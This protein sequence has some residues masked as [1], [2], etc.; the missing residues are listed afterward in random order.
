[1]HRQYISLLKRILFNRTELNSAIHFTTSTKYRESQVA[2]IML[3]HAFQ[4]YLEYFPSVLFSMV[5]LLMF[6]TIRLWQIDPLS[7]ASFPACSVR[8]GF[9]AMTPLCIAGDVNQESIEFLKELKQHLA[10]NA[11]YK[12]QNGDQKR[13]GAFHASCPIIKCTS[14]SLY[15]FEHSI[16]PVTVDNCAQGA[17][18]L[19]LLYE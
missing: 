3:N 1:M 19:L 4:Y 16:V 9:E 13:L 10:V 17:L 12:G 2:V 11:K 15:T 7:Y 6:S 18:N 5:S 8:C 14:G